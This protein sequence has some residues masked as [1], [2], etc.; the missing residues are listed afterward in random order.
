MLLNLRRRFK[1]FRID[2]LH[3]KLPAEG[4]N[5]VINKFKEGKIDILV[6][7]SVVEVGV[8]IPNATC[9]IV[10]NPE[11]FGLSQLHQLRG[12][13]MRSNLKPYFFMI[14]EDNVSPDILARLKVLTESTNGFEIAEQDLRL[15][16]PGDIF[17]IYQHG[18]LGASIV[19]PLE[20]LKTLKQARRFAF[21][22]VKKDPYLNLPQH[23]G[24]KEYINRI[25]DKCILWREN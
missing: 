15:R 23:K 12:R 14:Y 11:K 22:V 13:I 16:G 3:S 10:E 7:T 24:L 25:M 17:G 5:L 2:T 1:K 20:D 6:C 19:S 18:Y 8:D 9:M 4:K 21:E